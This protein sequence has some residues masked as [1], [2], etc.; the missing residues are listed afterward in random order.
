[1]IAI[2]QLLQVLQTSEAALPQSTG[3]AVN[4]SPGGLAKLFGA[5]LEQARATLGGE[6]ALPDGSA[7]PPAETGTVVQASGEV[8]GGEGL[9]TNYEGLPIEHAASVLEAL[10]KFET[11]PIEHAASVLEALEQGAEA[12]LA[13]GSQEVGL[14]EPETDSDS[15]E[16]AVTGTVN[17]V[18]EVVGELLAAMSA[19]P[20]QAAP[21][22]EVQTTPQAPVAAAKPEPVPAQDSH[23]PP[24]AVSEPTHLDSGLLAA[25][26]KATAQPAEF[27]PPGRPPGSVLLRAAAKSAAQGE[28]AADV[29]GSAVPAPPA[30]EGETG[31]RPTLS[32]V[33]ARAATRP[34]P[35]GQP[36]SGAATTLAE[37]PGLDVIEAPPSVAKPQVA[38][39]QALAPPGP[40]EVAQVAAPKGDAAIPQSIPE[41]PPPEIVHVRDLGDFTVKTVRYLAG[42]NEE[43][44]TV[45][46]VPRSLGELHIAVRSTGQSIDIVMTAATHAAREALEA[47]LPGL[48]EA[49][50]RPG[51]EVTSVTIQTSTAG[52]QA[53]GHFGP[54]HSA[55]SGHGARTAMNF[56]GGQSEPQADPRGSPRGSADH[57]GTLNMFV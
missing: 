33:F 7:V 41:R 31:E 4:S 17:S 47:Q 39:V 40:V 55:T 15:G 53:P 57:D 11:L 50:V 18:D 27:R 36:T 29:R 44:V 2:S 46:L 32:D 14:G 23:M 9:A 54:G 56:T 22:S 37:M 3:A 21:V 48:R 45:R 13:E 26:S 38:P 52:D 43:V 24:R 8:E 20:V 1:M 35:Q 16:G 51:G 42:R 34:Q 12:A 49:L 28:P 6:V 25:A 10:G 5:I 30:M 19:V